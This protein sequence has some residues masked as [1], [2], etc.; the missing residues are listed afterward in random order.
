MRMM[1]MLMHVVVT[2][3]LD[4]ALNVA[5]ACVTAIVVDCC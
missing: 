4:V 5:D 2:A 3:S 1:K